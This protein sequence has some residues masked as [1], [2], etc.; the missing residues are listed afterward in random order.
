MLKS[1]IQKMYLK[2]YFEIIPVIN[3][4]MIEQETVSIQLQI[5]A[6]LRL[7]LSTE[8]WLDLQRKEVILEMV[9]R[10]A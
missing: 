7:I 4:N 10:R 9:N 5:L 6:T 3:A 2:L 8:I 1:I